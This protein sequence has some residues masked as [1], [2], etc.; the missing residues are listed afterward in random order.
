MNIKESARNKTLQIRKTIRIPDPLTVA[1]SLKAPEFGPGILFFSG[2]SALRKLSQ[3]IIKYS[4]NTIHLITPFDSG[5]SSAKIRDSFKMLSV[6]DLRNRLMALADKSIKGNPDIYELFSYRFSKDESEE[7]LLSRLISMIKGHNKMVSC[8]PDPMRK[9]IRNHLKI[10]LNNMHDFSLRGAS[11]GNLILTGGYLNNERHIDPVVFLF[12]KLVEV[13]ATVRPVINEFMDIAVLLQDGS[14]FVGQHLLSGKEHEPVKSPVKEI[15]LTKSR[16][17][18]VKEN[19]SIRQ[20]TH[21]LI[22]DADLI[23]YPMGS[24]YSSLIANFLPAGVGSAIS[25]NKCLKVYIPNTGN[26]PEQLGMKM[27]DCIDNLLFY[28][29][30]SCSE[31]VKEEDIL[32]YIIM[33]IKNGD[34]P[35]LSDI[36]KYEKLGIKVVNTELITEESKPYIDEDKLIPVLLSLA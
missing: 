18:P 19:I 31:K 34:Y 23:C 16:N 32:N 8:I 33:D 35:E 5:G 1:K 11:I 22:M 30:S 14:M 10:F 28:L 3:E 36:D 2:G 12:S 6:G 7:K 24:F 25:A 29:Q 9:I 26:D 20:K 27:T 4:H 21:D 17:K 15:F 13:R